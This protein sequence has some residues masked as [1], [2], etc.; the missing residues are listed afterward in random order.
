MK[1]INVAEKIDKVDNGLSIKDCVL[2][3]T[4]ILTG[5]IGLNPGV[6]GAY[7]VVPSGKVITM[8]VGETGR[9]IRTRIQEHLK[10]WVGNPEFYCG[11]KESELEQG[12]KFL[13]RVLA[14]EKDA[15]KRYQKEQDLC[16]TMKPYLQCGV[17]PKF[18]TSYRGFDLCIFP[19][20]RR[21][22]FVIAR[23]GYYHEE[24]TIVDMLNQVIEKCRLDR[25]TNAVPN[26]MTIGNVEYEMP[27]GS[28]MHIAVKQ[29]VEKN[30]GITSIRGCNYKYL[31]RTVAAALDYLNMIDSVDYCWN[32]SIESDN[33]YRTIEEGITW[34]QALD[35]IDIDE[36]VLKDNVFDE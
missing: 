6:Y 8:Y 29:L 25:F 26:I 15:S 11:V 9:D 30:L 22:A 34:E 27:K 10:Y 7:V 33:K 17:Y 12:T 16:E 19:T 1:S 4:G 23:D 2:D 31:V 28:D 21:R 13:I 32:K 5:R 18:N 35:E 14:I 36:E 3:S 24:K 20:Y